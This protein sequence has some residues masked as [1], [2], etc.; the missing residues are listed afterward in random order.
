[1][2]ERKDTP[3]V[4][5]ASAAAAA[6]AKAAKPRLV[7]R[8]LG[9]L[10]QNL[11]VAFICGLVLIHAG[12]FAA[13]KLR[14]GP[15]PLSNE[16]ALGDFSFESELLPGNTVRSAVFRLHISLLDRAAYRG[17][18]L[19]V[20]RQ[21]KLQQEIEQLLRQAHGADFEDPTLTELKRQLQALVNK[22]LGER[23]VEEVIITDLVVERAVAEPSALP[24]GVS[25]PAPWQEVPPEAASSSL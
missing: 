25:E 10:K 19:L 14:S 12:L 4:A 20:A 18:V 15:A 24:A 11:I 2:A 22:T 16:V 17:R 9:L 6:P 8:I 3:K 21:A 23:V 5:E 1:M 13:W 7:G